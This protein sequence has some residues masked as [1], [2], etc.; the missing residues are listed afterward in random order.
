M[1]LFV[2][3]L[4]I[5]L[6]LSFRATAIDRPNVLVIFADDIGYEA[7]NSYGGQDFETPNLNRMAKQGLRFSRAY[8]S[9][10]CTPSRVSLHTGLYVKRHGYDTVLPVHLGTEK[11]VD[12]QKMPTFAQQIRANGYLTSVTGKW[13]L[14]TIQKHPDHIRNAGFD[15]WCVWQI[16]NNGEKTERHWNPYFNQDGAIRKDLAERFGRDLSTGGILFAV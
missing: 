14:A 9:P 10:V 16:W 15:S 11:I 1:K 7:L 6:L 13:Q 3:H 12:F 5:V 8:T 4:A 2:A